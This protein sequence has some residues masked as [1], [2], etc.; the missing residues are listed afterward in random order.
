V[1]DPD[2]TIVVATYERPAMLEGALRSVQRAIVV[3]REAGIGTRVIVVDDASP[4]TATREVVDRIGVDYLRNP[5]N[6]GRRTPAGARVHGV[7]EVRSRYFC[8]F[9][10]DDVMLPEFILLS[11]AALRAGAD[12]VQQAYVVTDSELRAR[13]TVV[14]YR[15]HLGDMLA[16]H[17]AVNDFA[18]V[19]TERASDVWDPV[20]G[21]M[22]MFGAW[23]ELAFRGA[24]F[25]VVR[26][27]LFRY[28]RHGT[29]MSDSRDAEY[30]RTRADLVARYREKVRLRDGALPGPS[31]RLRFHRLAAPA[32]RVL[33][34]R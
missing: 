16:D 7:A 30:W 23:L 14:P 21:K 25:Q 31:L 18:M 8:F 28:R 33:L 19:V 20:L 4:T 2:V 15:G 22:M 10:D 29:N 6:D 11:V 27:P 9:D 12:V 5:E 3:A 34:G 1:A 13:R 17:N 24:R 26:R 32:G